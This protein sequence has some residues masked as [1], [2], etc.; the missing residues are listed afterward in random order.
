MSKE[1]KNEFDI[2][3][4]NSTYPDAEGIFSFVPRPLKDIKDD[5]LIVLDTNALLVPHTTGKESLQQIGN[6]YEK[7]VSAGRLFVPGQVARE[8]ADN[9]VN[10]IR[11]LY[12]QV[13]TK[14][15]NIGLGNY[16]LL[17]SV[18]QYQKAR[19]LELQLKES[20]R[21][22]NNGISEVLNVISDWYWN[23]P[24]SSLYGRLFAS[25]VIY[26]PS[27]D[28]GDLVRKLERNILYK[29]PPAYKDAAKDDRGIGDLVIW[30][31]ILDLAKS[32][33]VDVIFVSLETKPDWWIS[34]N[35]RNLFPRY[36]LIDEFRRMSDGKSLHIIKFSEFL[37]EYGATVKTVQE[38]QE[39][40]VQLALEL[41]EPPHRK[42]I[43]YS[44]D[45]EEAVFKWLY[46]LFPG[47][48]RFKERGDYVDIVVAR[49]NG[50][51]T[52]V[53]VA[54][55][56][57]T[58]NLRHR[59]LEKAERHEHIRESGKFDEFI[60]VL[61]TNDE[62]VLFETMEYLRRVNIHIPS[63][64]IVIGHTGVDG[65]FVPASGVDLPF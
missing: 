18:L 35:G 2:F 65:E 1:D 13:A 61:V 6:I 24:V 38:V 49:A 54:Y 64:T 48:V 55:V 25:G 4:R 57:N 21:E 59:I 10:K 23:D 62:T 42:M 17:D 14:K 19:E 20:I 3:I 50:V 37:E 39:E 53:T 60:I 31:T 12:Q 46:H 22:Y 36:E 8:F 47:N 33:K 7:L 41:T 15:I 29:L 40:E 63:T 30:E 45:T 16:P 32:K 26:D 34:S 51:L 11:E 58:R 52:G 5:C 56:P 28:R 27:F 44:L 9:R 43:R